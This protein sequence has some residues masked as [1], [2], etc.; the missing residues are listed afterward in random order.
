MAETT[1]RELAR[2]AYDT[3]KSLR[4][5]FDDAA[6][7]SVFTALCRIEK[8]T[9][10]ES[11]VGDGGTVDIVTSFSTEIDGSDRLSRLRLAISQ[12]K[13]THQTLFD[14]EFFDEAEAYGNHAGQL[15]EALRQMTE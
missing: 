13:T 9:L 11:M 2:A 7:E 5:D 12:L 8:P 14:K 10:T 1:I 15:E 4:D 6:D 3:L